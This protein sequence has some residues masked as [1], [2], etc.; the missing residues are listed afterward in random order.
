[1]GNGSF[2]PATVLSNCSPE[3]ACMKEE[4]FG[5]VISLQG[6]SSEAQVIEIANNSSAGLAAYFYSQQV[7]QI[8]RVSERLQS[9]MV[10]INESA[11]STAEAPFGGVKNSGIGREGGPDALHEFMDTKYVCWGSLDQK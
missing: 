1:E 6:F 8:W 7:D 2:Y 4:I 11:I 9:G 10:G 5:P 3:M